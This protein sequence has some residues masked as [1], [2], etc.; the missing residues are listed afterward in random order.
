MECKHNDFLFQVMFSVVKEI[1][2]LKY[3]EVV[4]VKNC[5]GFNK[6]SFILNIDNFN[7][8]CTEL[9]NIKYNNIIKVCYSSSK[10]HVVFNS[11]ISD[12]N[13]ICNRVSSYIC[14]TIGKY[15]KNKKEST[16]ESKRIS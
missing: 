14:Y 7:I 16:N 11:Y 1:N 5:I 9:K 6:R 2:K 8:Y 4:I 3:D 13:D 10:D 12:T 15:L